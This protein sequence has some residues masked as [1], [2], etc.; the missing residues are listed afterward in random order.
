MDFIHADLS[1]K[2]TKQIAQS[3][4]EREKRIGVAIY[5]QLLQMHLRI[6]D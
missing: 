2:L 1:A 4:R 3:V 5:L 6:A